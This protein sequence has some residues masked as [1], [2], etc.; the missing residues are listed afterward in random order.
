V[1]EAKSGGGWGRLREEKG[2]VVSGECGSHARG[3]LLLL[4][5]NT[6]NNTP[7][8]I[9]NDDSLLFAPEHDQVVYVDLGDVTFLAV[10]FIDAVDEL[11]LDGNFLTFL[12]VFFR[13]AGEFSPD[14]DIVP[15]GVF[16]L[17]AFL[18]FV[19]VRG[20]NGKPCLLAVAERFYFRIFSESSDELDAVS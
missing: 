8:T 9:S 6:N 15:L 2:V 13:N 5:K 7:T 18:V 17:F 11:T 20:C 3:V 12:Q 10:G 19:R 1:F 4:V 14:D 16:D